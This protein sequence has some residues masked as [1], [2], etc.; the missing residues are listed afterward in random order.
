MHR[1]TKQ[2]AAARKI[3]LQAAADVD[4]GDHVTEFDM[5]NN[6]KINV[7]GQFVR[8]HLVL[9]VTADS[10]RMSAVTRIGLQ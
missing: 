5:S 6:R 9:L 3:K 1:L 8:F 2:L 7:D 4:V 10:S